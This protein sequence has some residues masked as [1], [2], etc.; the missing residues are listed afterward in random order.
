MTTEAQGFILVEAFGAKVPGI[1]MGNKGPGIPE[2][3]IWS[4][5]GAFRGLWAGRRDAVRDKIHE[6]R[7][8][9]GVDLNHH[10]LVDFQSPTALDIVRNFSCGHKYWAL[11][12]QTV[13]AQFRGSIA[14]YLDLLEALTATSLFLCMFAF[15]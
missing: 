7:H 12:W 5:R 10:G 9:G 11:T 6:A 8:R 13:H 15:L 3:P 2:G 1:I 14:V 4:R